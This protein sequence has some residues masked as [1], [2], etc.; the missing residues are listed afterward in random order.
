MTTGR[1][2]RGSS[3]IDSGLAVRRSLLHALGA[4]EPM[5]RLATRVFSGPNEARK[6]GKVKHEA[7]V[8]L[9]A[10]RLAEQV[11][12]PCPKIVEHLVGLGIEI[13]L[14]DVR[15]YVEYQSRALLVPD[16]NAEPY[17]E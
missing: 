2:G 16:E 17:I 5:R 12:L 1:A 3:R 10:R 14:A 11:H 15:R 4:P 8:V 9:E 7:S 13:D 6:T